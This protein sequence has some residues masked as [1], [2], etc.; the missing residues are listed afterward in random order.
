[1]APSS[2][3]TST[4]SRMTPSR[5][6]APHGGRRRFTVSG[7]GHVR[8]PRPAAAHVRPAAGFLPGTP[9]ARLAGCIRRSATMKTPT[10]AP[11]YLDNE[12]V[13]LMGD[14]R[15]QVSKVIAATGKHPEKFDVKLLHSETDTEGKT[16]DLD[17]V[18]DRTEEPTKAI[19]LTTVEKEGGSESVGAEGAERISGTPG[20]KS[21]AASPGSS[22]G[23]G[24]GSS[25][26]AYG[27]GSKSTGMGGAGKTGN[28][29]SGGSAQGNQGFGFGSGKAENQGTST[30]N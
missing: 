25:G 21:G 11:V 22:T 16:L 10:L 29:G 4:T 3:R 17:Y 19:Y 15:P 7:Q 30:Q 18:I 24:S 26:G 27:F 12:P 13:S 1:M 8:G 5:A 28:I 23:V 14:P 6:M 9:F 20:T 2:S